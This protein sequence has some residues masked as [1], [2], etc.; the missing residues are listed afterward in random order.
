MIVA[1]SAMAVAAKV[2]MTQ[3]KDWVTMFFHSQVVQ[4]MRASPCITMALQSL[5]TC[6]SFFQEEWKLGG[7]WVKLRMVAVFCQLSTLLPVSSIYVS[8]HSSYFAIKV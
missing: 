7:E 5:L 6:E 1:D 8:L 4:L 3:E 2:C